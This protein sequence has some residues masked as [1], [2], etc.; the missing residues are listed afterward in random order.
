MEF[1][2]TLPKDFDFNEFSRYDLN[3]PDIKN[4]KEFNI[5]TDLGFKFTSEQFHTNFFNRRSGKSISYLFGVIIEKM[6]A[7]DYHDEV[8]IIFNNRNQFNMFDCFFTEKLRNIYILELERD[9]LKVTMRNRK[10]WKI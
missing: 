10:F 4:L 7:L 6:K 2:N 3:N 1:I 5:L 8:S 9:K